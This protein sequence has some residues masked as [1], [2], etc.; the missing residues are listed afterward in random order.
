M[1]GGYFNEDLYN[2]KNARSPIKTASCPTC[3]T[4]QCEKKIADRIFSVM[5]S[6]NIN[7]K[8]NG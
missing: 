7:F 3:G 1:T 8:T 6:F 2:K 4:T 5:F